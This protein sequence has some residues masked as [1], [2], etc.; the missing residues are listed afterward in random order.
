MAR[1][2]F[3][4][5]TQTGRYWAGEDDSKFAWSQPLAIVIIAHYE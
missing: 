3:R 4:S 2:L 5:P 1:L